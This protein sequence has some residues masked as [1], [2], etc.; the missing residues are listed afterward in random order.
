MSEET[1]A[2]DLRHG[3]VRR[4]VDPLNA[5]HERAKQQHQEADIADSVAAAFD[6]GTDIGHPVVLPYERVGYDIE[7]DVG[8]VKRPPERRG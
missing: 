8:T 3:P 4:I 1:P 5:H 6:L 2:P 7:S